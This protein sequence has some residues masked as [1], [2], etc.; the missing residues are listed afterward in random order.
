MINQRP[1][2]SI[3]YTHEYNSRRLGLGK[4]WY[5]EHDSRWAY[6]WPIYEMLCSKQRY[7]NEFCFIKTLEFLKLSFGNFKR[8]SNNWICK[9][10]VNFCRNLYNFETIILRSFM[11]F[12][13]TFELSFLDANA[14]NP[15]WEHTTQSIFFDM[16]MSYGWRSVFCLSV[17]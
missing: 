16:D 5:R 2:F 10:R 11:N 12:E 4:K 15:S 8:S 17:W 13:T 14:S 9:L 7:S 6:R 3:L 1:I